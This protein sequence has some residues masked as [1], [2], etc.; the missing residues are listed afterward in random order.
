M[1]DLLDIT[2]VMSD[3]LLLAIILY[4]WHCPHSMQTRDYVTARFPSVCMSVPPVCLLQL[5]A[6]VCC[7]GPGG[8]E[9]DRLL[10]GR[11]RNT[12]ARSSKCGQWHV[13][14]WRRK[15]KSE[16]RLHCCKQCILSVRMCLDWFEM[17]MGL[18]PRAVL[19]YR[20][21]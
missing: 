2:I 14:S 10:R 16:D 8:E 3:F 6:P 9:I 7:W 1:S 18:I 20:C 15:L 21:F 11:R 17:N 4:Y 13:Y 5:R 12:T 19:S